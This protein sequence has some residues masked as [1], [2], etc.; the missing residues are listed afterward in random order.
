MRGTYNRSGN[1]VSDATPT[2]GYALD[3]ASHR[4]YQRA[5][6]VHR[7]AEADTHVVRAEGRKVISE[8]RRLLDKLKDY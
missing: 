5:E 4:K 1:K 6:R 7:R 8:H 3:G 2:A